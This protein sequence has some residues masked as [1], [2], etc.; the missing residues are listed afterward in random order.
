[1]NGD[2][3]DDVIVSA[4]GYTNG[5]ETQEGAAF[6]YLGSEDGVSTSPAWSFEGGQA[7]AF[8]G[9]AAETAGDVNGDGYD[10][11]IVG[12][13]NYDVTRTDQGG[14][15]VFLGSPQGLSTDPAWTDSGVQPDVRYGFAAT[16]AGDVNGDGLD[17][18]IVGARRFDNGETNEGRAFV[19]HG[20]LAAATTSG[21]SVDGP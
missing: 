10:D 4:V 20:P 1:V 7:D 19:Y 21:C 13:E 9:W 17:D 8:L 16:A 5:E 18:V 14:A 15:W 12:T 6:V 2:G 3:Y 11:V